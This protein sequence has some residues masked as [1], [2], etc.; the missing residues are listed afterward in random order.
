MTKKKITFKILA[1][2]FAL[3]GIILIS[4]FAYQSIV[5]AQTDFSTV[6]ENGSTTLNTVDLEDYLDSLPTPDLTQGEIDGI[7]YMAEEE[8]LARDVYLY[9][10]NLWGANL[11][12]N[13]K[14]SEETHMYA[15]DLLIDKY[16]ITFNAT[17]VGVFNNQTLQDLY[18]GLITTGQISLL[19]ALEVGAAIEEIDIIDLVEY[20]NDTVNEDLLFVYEILLMGS[21]NHLRA[22]VKNISANGVTYAPQFLEEADYEGIIAGDIE[23]A[24]SD[25]STPYF[26]LLGS[27][28][29]LLIGII[30]FMQSKNRINPKMEQ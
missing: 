7:V 1:G 14:N 12:N 25:Q 9:L 4:F 6:D 3:T 28:I 20:M 18:D 15:V 8:K 21:R 17:A 30:F 24:N 27:I 16:N 10:Y 11:F 22:F 26:F 29:S 13:I 5:Q 19:D 23:N 2:V